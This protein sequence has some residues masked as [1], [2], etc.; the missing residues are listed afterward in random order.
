MRRVV[1]ANQDARESFNAKTSELIDIIQQRN[2]DLLDA[3]T[4]GLEDKI[5][6]SLD[7]PGEDPATGGVDG[8]REHD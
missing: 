6:G 4:A 5:R 2:P 8:D 7:E 1:K 3:F